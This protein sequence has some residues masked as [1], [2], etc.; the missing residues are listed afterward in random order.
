MFVLGAIVALAACARAVTAIAHERVA[1][2]RLA[3]TPTCT[4][5]NSTFPKGSVDFRQTSTG[6]P[7]IAISPNGSWDVG[8]NGLELF[9]S[10]PEG[11][12]TTSDGVNSQLG[13]GATVNSTFTFLYGKVTYVVTGVNTPGIVTAAILIGDSHDELDIE[14][15]GGDPNN[16]QTNVFAT[17]PADPAPLV[18]AFGDTQPYQAGDV[19]DTH[20]YT[21][22]WNEERVIWSVDGQQVRTLGPNDTMKNGVTHY[23]ASPVRLQMGVW[24]GSSPQGTC[25]WAKGP[26]EW[27]TAPSLMTAY[28]NSVS[29]ECPYTA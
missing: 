11:P 13:N 18:G 4:P 22:D 26:V 5:F 28:I 19:K 6:A 1:H 23:P 12:V 14:L 27:T 3:S 29:V 24:D 8:S 7:F 10:K 20:N 16:W 2:N 15:L 21:I 17:N 25:E 9:M